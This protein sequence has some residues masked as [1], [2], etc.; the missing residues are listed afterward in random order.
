[1]YHQLQLSR[2]VKPEC[3]TEHANIVGF[4]AAVEALP[5]VSEYAIRPLIYG[6]PSSHPPPPSQYGSYLNGRPEAV[7]IG[8]KPALAPKDS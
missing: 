5:G 8:V 6:N 7:G 1:M 4:M 2:L 3:L